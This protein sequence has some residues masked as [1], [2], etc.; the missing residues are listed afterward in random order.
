MWF[1][2]LAPVTDPLLVVSAIAQTFGVQE[3]GGESV[4]AML[5]R[6]LRD[7]QLLLVLDNFEQVVDA[8]PLI[9]TLLAGAQRLKVLVTSRVSLRVSSEQEFPVPTLSTAHP[10][11]LPELEV[12]VQFEAVALFIQRAQ[13]VKPDFQVTNATA[14]AVAEICYRLEGMPLAIELAAARGAWGNTAAPPVPPMS[15]LTF[16]R[17]RLLPIRGRVCSP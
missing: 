2:A 8:A 6:H 5:L 14:P 15:L 17:L 4:E 12:L 9:S 13:A 16:D 10:K 11:A 3:S 7:K 1:V